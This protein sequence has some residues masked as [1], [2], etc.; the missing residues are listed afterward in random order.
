MIGASSPSWDTEQGCT[1]PPL[2]HGSSTSCSERQRLVSIPMDLAQTRGPRQKSGNG[3]Q[4]RCAMGD[5]NA[6]G[7]GEHAME[8]MK[9]V[10]G[11][12]GEIRSCGVASNS[13][14]CVV[15]VEIDTRHERIVVCR[16]DIEFES[17]GRHHQDSICRLPYTF[18]VVALNEIRICSPH[19]SQMS[20]TAAQMIIRGRK[21]NVKPFRSR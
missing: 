13:I 6:N 7:L 1:Y 18:S 4:A 17:C 14:L 20:V 9:F 16:L 15:V 19:S 21:V 2:H 10:K 5:L 12:G 11:C 3:G 8:A